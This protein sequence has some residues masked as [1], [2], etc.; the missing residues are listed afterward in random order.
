MMYNFDKKVIMATVDEKTFSKA[1][2]S[3]GDLI[4]M[5]SSDI[6]TIGDKINLAHKMGKKVFVHLDMADGIGKDRYGVEFLRSRKVDGVI[7]TKNNIVVAC[8]KVG[9]AVVQRFFIIDS[10]SIETAIESVK[11]T[12]PDMVELMPG[13]VY[14]AIERFSKE[15]NIPVIAGGLIATSDEVKKAINYGASA[16]S[17]TKIPLWTV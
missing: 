3:D 7:T 4:F 10:K 5:L 1:I 9:M 15:V 17:T 13:V 2:S 11:S 16:V 14:K 8:K 6:L 12:R